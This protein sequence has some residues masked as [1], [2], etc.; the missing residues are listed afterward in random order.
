MAPLAGPL[1]EQRW[2]HIACIPWSA[3]RPL[4]LILL[5]A[6]AFGQDG[7]QAA[8]TLAGAHAAVHLAARDAP[9]PQQSLTVTLA[10]PL[11]T[12]VPLA[13]AGSGPIAY[14][15]LVDVPSDAPADLGMG[16]WRADRQGRWFQRLLPER[17]RPGRQLVLLDLGNDA[18]LVAEGNRGRWS[19]E[20]AADADHAGLFLYS[21]AAS[22]AAIHLDVRR[23]AVQAH[24]EGPWQLEDLAMPLQAA[25]GKRWSLTLR[26]DPY[27]ADPYNPAYFSL[28]LEVR[29]PDGSLR[30]FAGFHDE[31]VRRVDRGDREEFVTAGPACFRVRFRPTCAGVHHLHLIAQ[32]AGHPIRSVELP[33]VVASGPDW[34]DIARV[35]AGDPRFFSAAGS[36]VWPAGCSLNSIYDTRCRGVMRTTLTPDRGS[37]SRDA[38]LER[39]A[40]G[41]GTGCEVWLSPWNLGLEWVPDWPGYRGAGRYHPGHA[42]AFDD[43][44][45]RAEQLGVR[46]NVCLFN[47]GMARDGNGAEDDWKHHPYATVNGGWLTNPE[48]LFTDERAFAYQC[49]LYRY[50]A[51]RYGDSPALLGWK[52]WAEV[53]LAHAPLDAI[54]DWHARASAALSAADPWKHPITTHWCGDWSS[55]ERRTAALPGLTYLT[56]DAYKGNE[57]SIADL[58][59]MSTLDPQHPGA[60]LALLGK[61]VLV[62]EFGGSTGGT[63]RPRMAVEHAIG[64]WAG[65]VSGHCGSPML[66]WFEW[67]DQEDRFGV[68]GAVNRFA[69][70]E[71]LRGADARCIALDTTGDDELWCLGWARPGRI[72]GYL[73]DRRWSLGGAEREI[74]HAVV[75]VGTNLA[76]GDMA[77][78]WWDAERGAVVGQT[79]IHHHGGPLELLAPAFHHH[80]A[81]KLMRGGGM[82]REQVHGG[83]VIPPRLDAEGGTAH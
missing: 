73:L 10:A 83:L 38:Y 68:Y 23:C 9:E 80:L 28:D 53:N 3:M 15:V 33:D 74:A 76:P 7:P 67:I 26:P 46:V 59:C 31:P 63:S 56:I 81:F 51:A 40:A 13:D 70:G 52:L 69:A 20:T 71:D 27:P 1:C 45:E 61:P 82:Q 8:G 50:L 65:L 41:G 48:G 18:P 19:A 47:H 29:G 4:L 14:E 25:T 5:L 32:W 37:F 77:L 11:T 34:D 60:G 44:L 17:L 66:W 35:D 22:H 54:I 16:A 75:R 79:I 30:R 62:T 78:E 72:L 64:P 39:L 24:S 42:A 55:A 49:R 21:Q 2:F 43:F 57:T 12:L 58:L 6:A 36:F